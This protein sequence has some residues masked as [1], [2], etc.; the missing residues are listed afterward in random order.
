MAM[1]N[2]LGADLSRDVLLDGAATEARVRA[3]ELHRY[4]VLSFATHGV[5]SGELPGLAEPAL[6]LAAPQNGGDPAND[7]VLRA[8]EVLELSL[9]ARLVILSAC[10][11]AASAGTP[12][13]EGLSGLANAFIYAG[14][15]SLIVTHWQVPSGAA[16]RV[17]VGSGILYRQSPLNEQDWSGSLRASML[18]LM[19]KTGNPTNAHPVNWGA[20]IFVGMPEKTNF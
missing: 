20:F 4:E 15:R 11:T 14:A 8:S 7:G 12:G 19:D 18:E 5:L 13:A 3:A 2:L 6:L 1:S 10:N 16:L 9:N 17:S